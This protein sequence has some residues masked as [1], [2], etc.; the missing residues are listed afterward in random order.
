MNGRDPVAP[1]RLAEW[2]LRK[3]VEHE[4]LLGDLV[5]AFESRARRD[6]ASAARRWFWRETF[7]ALLVFAF[8]QP[9]TRRVHNAYVPRANGDTAMRS[10]L[11][12][13]R[14]GARLL[15]RSPAFTAICVLTLGIGIGATT[16]IFSVANPLLLQSL[17]YPDAD[18]LITV[19]DRAGDGSPTNV[20]FP[21]YEDLVERS[22]FIERA[23]V[24]GTWQ[25]TLSEPGNA[26]RITGERVSWT[27]FDV[28][29][30][31]PAIGRSFLEEEDQPGVERAVILT[32]GLWSRR[33]GGDSSV[34]GRAISIDGTPH[35]VVGVLPAAFE[36][37]MAPTAEIFRVLRYEASQPWACRT[38]RHLR[39]VAR[40]RP[41]APLARVDAELDAISAQ[42]ASEHPRDYASVGVHVLGLHEQ[43]TGNLRPVVLA[44]IGAAALV[45]LIAVANVTNLQ[46]ARAMRREGEFAIRAAIGAGRGRL[47]RQL[48]AEGLLLGA[49][50]GAIGVLVAYVTVPA[51]VSRLPATLPRLSAVQVD[52]VA[53]GLAAGVS[54]LVGIVIGL[55]PAWRGSRRSVFDTLRGGKRLAGSPRLVARAGLVVAEVALALV[56]LTGAG[57]LSR[58]LLSLHA[59][60]AGFDAS[61]LLTLQAQA[62]GAR[63]ETDSAVLVQHDRLRSAVLALP[64]VTGAG[65]VSQL[66]LGGNMDAYGIRA[67]DKPLD[68]PELAPYADRYAVSHDF[69]ETMRIPLRRGR[70][71]TPADAE[72]APL[73]VIVSEALAAKIWPGED[74]IGKRIQVGGPS[75]VPF[76]DVVGVAANVRHSGLD[77]GVTQQVYLPTRQWKWADNQFAMV[78][79]TAGDPQRLAPAVRAAV[80]ETDPDQPITSFASM[81]QVVS[82]S[83]AQ[84]SLA[85]LLFAAF[86]GV[87]VL[88]AAAGIYGVLSGHVAERTREIGVRSALGAAPADIM[89]TVLGQ[90]ARL[91]A[92]GLALGIVGALAFARLLETLL[93]GVGAADPLTLGAVSAVLALV[94]VA[95][96]VVPAR[97]ALRVDPMTALR[98][99]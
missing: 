67:Q 22:R 1:P 86:A 89:R 28:L 40:V 68:N 52:L 65:I 91:A 57:L 62:T 35:D 66:P 41:D 34:I 9:R 75:D 59:V 31:R 53:L 44:V 19:F 80:R 14:L 61:N 93:F 25:P 48:L 90:G 83:T 84:R 70:Y 23:A 72:N 18:R 95:A 17:P 92:I 76:R 27:Y 73:V 63:Y 50:G 85:L 10:F 58:T 99:E 12:D 94:A 47:V 5:E 30:V 32:H 51:L 60:N 43:V 21:T 20:G 56:L 87:A 11:S 77:D 54:L 37:V 71:F 69:M 79:R 16:A 82:S 96:C 49:L 46:L 81:E 26:E 36:N 24:A 29:G 7:V 39:M 3:T 55:A 4:P 33:Y 45:L 78:V 38:C 2:M 97:R 74:P 42:L 98:S 6:G 15:R 8:R 64:G 88:L 13:L